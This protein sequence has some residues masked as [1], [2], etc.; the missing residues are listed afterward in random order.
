[1]SDSNKK[2]SPSLRIDGQYMK[3]LSISSPNAPGIFS[4][5][6]SVPDVQVSC[7]VNANRLNE[8]TYEVSLIIKTTAMVKK[9]QGDEEKNIEAFLCDLSYCGLITLGEMSKED[10]GRTLLVYVPSMLFP[11]ARRIIS[12]ATT[13]I[14]FPP[15]ML[16]NIDFFSRYEQSLNEENEKKGDNEGEL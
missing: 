13:D 15:L 7:D 16:D 1:M 2:N 8:S 11:F 4:K 9:K 14:G 12:T 10:R 6:S 3:N 5:D